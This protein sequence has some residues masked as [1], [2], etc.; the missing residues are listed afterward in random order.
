MKTSN[1]EKKNTLIYNKLEMNLY[2]NY[3]STFLKYLD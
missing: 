1:K 3:S 2:F